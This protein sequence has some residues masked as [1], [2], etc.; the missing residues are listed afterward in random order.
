MG[1]G[2]VIIFHIIQ[3]QSYCSLSSNINFTT[4]IATFAA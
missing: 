2:N 1:G 3:A 4:Q